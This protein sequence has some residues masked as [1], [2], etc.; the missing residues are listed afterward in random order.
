MRI[1]VLSAAVLGLA[2]FSPAA[3]AA[4]KDA[5]RVAEGKQVFDYNCVACHGS[6]VGYPGF[7][8]LPGT[9]AL[10]VKY[11]GEMPALLADRTDLTPEVVAYFVRNGVSVMPPYR[12][13]EISDEQLA[14]LGAY[15]S[16]NN[17]DLRKGVRPQKK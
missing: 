1:V 2:S 15:L 6:G 10:T 5:A 8:G 3:A 4:G 17:P 16:R 12:K 13:T 11:K 9:E 7:Q 14:A